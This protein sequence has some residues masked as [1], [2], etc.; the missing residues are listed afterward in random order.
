MYYPMLKHGIDQPIDQRC[1]RLTPLP[2]LG[3]SGGPSWAQALVSPRMSLNKCLRPYAIPK[4]III[5]SKHDA[6]TRHPKIHAI[7]Y[8]ESSHSLNLSKSYNENGVF[9]FPF[10]NPICCLFCNVFLLHNISKHYSVLLMTPVLCNLALQFLQKGGVAVLCPVA[11]L[12][13]FP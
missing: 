13:T 10:V 9:T 11:V 2:V 7:P 1:I 6:S 8:T 12:G 4:N 3:T 5:R